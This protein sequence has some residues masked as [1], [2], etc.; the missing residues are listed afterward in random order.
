MRRALTIL[1]V[2]ALPQPAIASKPVTTPMVTVTELERFIAASHEIPD[3]QLARQIVAMKLTERLTRTEL[4]ELQHQ[5]AGPK[6][7]FALIAIADESSFLDLAPADVPTTPPPDHATQ[8]AILNKTMAYML[9]TVHD[10]PN[11]IANRATTQYLGTTIAVNQFVRDGLVPELRDSENGR[12]ITISATSV[13][14]RYSDGFESWVDPRKARK[15]Q[16]NGGKQRWM[17]GQFGELFARVAYEMAHGKMTWIRWE[18]DSSQEL[19]VYK[20]EATLTYT[21][22][23]RCPDEAP[24]LPTLS[25]V[26]GEV[27]VDPD[28]GKVRR[29][30]EARLTSVNFPSGPETYSDFAEIE[31]GPMRINGVVFFC[32]I[33]SS[34]EEIGP[35]PH[36]IET[37]PKGLDRGHVSYGKAVPE[38]INDNIDSQYRFF[39]SEAHIVDGPPR[40]IVSDPQTVPPNK[41][42]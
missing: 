3:K 41:P 34:I 23:N 38:L 26:S 8:V 39:K 27:A 18:R 11:L 21:A 4:G 15:T 10:L 32:P 14:V 6:A 1:L 2:T 19:A 40:I 24:A 20:Y 22:P 17:G 31:Y 28:D 13:L 9:H 12:L 42:N 7:H 30:T 25:T 37:G 29:L 33:S 16:C 5:V 36:D 35:L